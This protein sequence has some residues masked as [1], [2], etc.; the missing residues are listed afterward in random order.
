MSMS[1]LLDFWIFRFDLKC[2]VQVGN[3]GHSFKCFGCG[4]LLDLNYLS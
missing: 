2:L 1:L 3:A 4:G